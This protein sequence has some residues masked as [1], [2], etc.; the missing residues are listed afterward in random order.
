MTAGEDYVRPPLVATEPQPR[1]RVWPL[2]IG[3]LLL[4]A[5]VALVVVLV[6]RA[7]GGSGEGSPDVG[8]HSGL[9]PVV[10]PSSWVAARR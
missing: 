1:A 2:R 7:T 3:L 9:R 5:V 10:I 8:G 4:I 6:V